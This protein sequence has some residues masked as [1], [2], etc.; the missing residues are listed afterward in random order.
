MKTSFAGVIACRLGVETV[1]HGG[2]KIVHMH[3]SIALDI[4]GK[5]CQPLGRGAVLAV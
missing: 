5:H 4:G 1:I 2:E 3:A